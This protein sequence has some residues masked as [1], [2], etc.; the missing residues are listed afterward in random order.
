MAHFD[1]AASAPLAH[2]WEAALQSDGA[3]RARVRVMSSV[4]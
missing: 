3:R 1:G 4:R 2:M